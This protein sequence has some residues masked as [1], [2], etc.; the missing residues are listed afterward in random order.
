ML[1]HFN[2]NRVFYALLLFITAIFSHDIFLVVLL[3]FL[4]WIQFQKFLFFSLISFYL[5]NFILILFFFF[6]L[7]CVSPTHKKTKTK[8]SIVLM[9]M[10]N[11][12]VVYVDH[13]VWNN[14]IS[15]ENFTYVSH[16]LL[17][18]YSISIINKLV[19]NFFCIVFLVDSLYYFILKITNSNCV[20]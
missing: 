14:Q 4:F 9:W 15:G 12:V 5:F 10:L 2:L 17:I 16:L 18:V 8:R 6:A 7:K 19:D 13:N 3:N 11:V 20:F 1:F